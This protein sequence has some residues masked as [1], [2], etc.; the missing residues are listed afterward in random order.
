MKI[1]FLMCSLFLYFSSFNV[2]A[3]EE[4]SLRP[5]DR[6]VLSKELEKKS[7]EN[8]H[9][10]KTKVLLKKISDAIKPTDGNQAKNKKLLMKI[11]LSIGNGASW[12]STATAKPF[13]AG[14]G[15]IKGSLEKSDKNND[16]VSLYKL[17]LNHESEF[18]ELYKEAAT[19]E[20][21][22][23]IVLLKMESIVEVKVI[24]I[25]N[26]FLNQVGIKRDINDRRGIELTDEEIA[27]IPEELLNPDFI[28]NH[29]EFS[30][31]KNLVGEV[32]KQELIDAL[33][34]GVLY[35]SVAYD[36]Y[37]RAIPGRI[38]LI[39]TLVAQINAP[40]IA[41]NVISS[42][43]AG[44][45][46]GPILLADLATGISVTVCQGDGVREKLN[47][48]EDLRN[49][50]SYVT[51]R[52]GYQILK[53]RAKGYVAGKHFQAKVSEK[54][55]KLKKQKSSDLEISETKLH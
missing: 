52:S 44:L 10:N 12:V 25:V 39:S 26:D 29:P 32:S 2:S 7:K 23:D 21:F 36:L 31:M 6:E 8:G 51:N 46:A 19:P 37:Q 38:E 18:D 45:Y 30:E 43:L 48:D 5:E 17:F 3:Q 15:F 11:G 24:S 27:S 16:L 9:N 33:R 42:S 54:L 35:K 41:I 22:L 53:S 20:E 40:K 1:I 4:V 34:S 13:M 28:N 49:F 14:A 50:C 47:T 55:K